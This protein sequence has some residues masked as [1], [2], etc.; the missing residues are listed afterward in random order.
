MR[1][2]VEAFGFNFDEARLMGVSLAC[3]VIVGPLFFAMGCEACRLPMELVGARRNWS[4][5]CG[6]IRE[7]VASFTL[8]MATAD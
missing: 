7:L 2:V 4:A 8:K 3:F 6:V 5:Y 1:T